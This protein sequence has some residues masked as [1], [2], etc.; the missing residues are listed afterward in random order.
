[1]GD[2]KRFQKTK[3]KNKNKRILEPDTPPDYDNMAPLF[4]LQQIQDNTKYG[5]SKLTEKDKAS[6]SD[7]IYKRRDITWKELKQNSRHGLGF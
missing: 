6:F 2:K 4:S 1:M 3:L 7:A 5:F